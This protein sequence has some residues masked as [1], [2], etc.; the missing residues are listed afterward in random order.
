MNSAIIKGMGYY[1]PSNVVTNDDLAS[2]MDT[3][4]EWIV[5]RTGINE[6]RWI[7]DNSEST[8]SM[9]LEASKNAIADAEIDKTE[10]DFIIFATLSPDYYFP[11]PGVTLQ[12]DL[13]LDTV[14]ALDVR[15]QCSGFV[16]ALSIADQYIKTGM[17]K[18]I[19]VVGSEYHSGGLDKSTKGRGVTVIF[20]DG[21]GAAIVS[22]SPNADRGILSTH[23]HSQGE[24]AE[25]LTLLGPSTRRWVPEI[26][27]GAGK[28]DEAIYPYM[29]GTF[30]FKHA[31]TRFPQVI[32]E[33]LTQNNL[34]STDIN[35]LIPHQANLRISQ[36]VQQ[37]MGLRDDQ[38]FNNI[39]KYGNTT[40]ASIPIAL[41]EAK[42]AGKVK[43][44]DL[45]CLAAFGSG[46]TWASALIRW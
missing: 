21:A 24:F 1:V 10:I 42:L 41:A 11:G 2:I 18:N 8:S 32:G 43:E 5:E 40:A 22:K 34:K 27:D 31:V 29:N 25:E 23:L 4:N 39:Q 19:L 16:Y 9:A 38:V 33:A 12:K 46:F 26:I 15:N 7:K 6:R 17:Y 37:K 28:D 44:G 14:G 13:G 35:L 3:N 45:I 36:F 30:V 20:G